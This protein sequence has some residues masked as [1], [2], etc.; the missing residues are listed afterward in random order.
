MKCAS[1]ESVPLELVMCRRCTCCHS[2]WFCTHSPLL[3]HSMWLSRATPL[4]AC[5]HQARVQ[6]LQQHKRHGSAAERTRAGRH[7]P[8]DDEGPSK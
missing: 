1:A 5:G 3:P 4:H 8:K 2:D 7:A 6:E